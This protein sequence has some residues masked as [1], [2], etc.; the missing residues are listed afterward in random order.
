MSTLG[1]IW[2]LFVDF[3][4]QTPECAKHVLLVCELLDIK[5]SGIF[6]IKQPDKKYMQ[7]FGDKI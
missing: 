6:E 7:I 4:E 2:Q 3:S 5:K 1:I